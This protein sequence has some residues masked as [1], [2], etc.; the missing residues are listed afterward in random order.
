MWDPLT[1]SVVRGDEDTVKL[2]LK[3]KGIAVDSK[4]PK[5]R[6]PL[7]F[8]VEQGNTKITRLLL[9]AGADPNTQDAILRTPLHWAGSPMLAVNPRIMPDE[10]SSMK[11]GSISHQPIYCPVKVYFEDDIPGSISWDDAK[12]FPKYCTECYEA[13]DLDAAAPLS[14]ISLHWSAGEE[15]EEILRL[16]VQYGA[17]LDLRDEKSRTPLGW[18]ATCGYQP[19][20]RI[21]LE[22]GAV[23]GSLKQTRR[24]PLSWAAENGHTGIVQFLIGY[25]E[26]VEPVEYDGVRSASPL[27][28]AAMKGHYETVQLLLEKTINRETE[29]MAPDWR[30]LTD[31]AVAGHAKVVKLLLFAHAQKWPE[32]PIGSTAESNYAFISPSPQ[33]PS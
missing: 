28:Y 7:S 15:Y 20:L 21:L 23:L 22:N 16:L 26:S 30:P 12:S 17:N 6:T 13:R 29:Y 3:I 11:L 32:T 33:C 27:S 31:A 10:T 8:A 24:S 19:L 1:W 18:A 9:A 14:L 4:C 25:G 2:L 5:G